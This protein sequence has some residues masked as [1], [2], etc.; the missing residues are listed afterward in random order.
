VRRSLLDLLSLPRS[1]GGKFRRNRC[2]KAFAVCECVYAH[3]TL[4]YFEG[5]QKKKR[6]PPEDVTHSKT[7]GT[8]KTRGK[9]SNKHLSLSVLRFRFGFSYDRVSP[10]SLRIRARTY[11]YYARYEKADDSYAR[12]GGANA[13]REIM[14]FTNATKAKVMRKKK[15][16]YTQ[17]SDE[18]R[19]PNRRS[20]LIGR[21]LWRANTGSGSGC[22]KRQRSYIVRDRSTGMRDA[23]KDLCTGGVCQWRSYYRAKRGSA[24]EPRSIGASWTFLKLYFSKIINNVDCI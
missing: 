1:V 15:N 24:L 17:R 23:R 12:S 3:L 18:K 11:A 20:F 2:R 8:A 7:T 14:L 6:K 22:R 10:P 21:I 4:L 13:T 5:K 16:P 9:Y 19:R